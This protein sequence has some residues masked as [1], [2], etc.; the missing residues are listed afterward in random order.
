MIARAYATRNGAHGDH[1][2][3]SV[4]SGENDAVRKVEAEGIH[5]LAPLLDDLRTL[6]RQAG[7]Y[8]AASSD[9]VALR[10]RRLLIWA[11]VGCVGAIA[12]IAMVVVAVSLLLHGIADGLGLLVGAWAGAL[13]TGL[14][15]LSAIALSLYLGLQ[16][17][18]T[19]YS[20]RMR[21]KHERRHHPNR[22]SP[23]R[24]CPTT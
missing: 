8:L 16:R 2:P 19:A 23:V 3:G 20:R 1:D 11:I 12:G 5:P 18:R 7:S 6:G 9:A 21:K 14:V 22:A 15:V 13:L 17:A 24:S 4:G 10:I